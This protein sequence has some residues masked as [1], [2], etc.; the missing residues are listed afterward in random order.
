VQ[1]FAWWKVARDGIYFI[2]GSTTPAHVRILDVA[3]QRVK[4]IASMDLGYVVPGAQY[5]DL[6]P[7]GQW[8]LFD[9]GDQVESDIMLVEN[10]R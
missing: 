1:A 10:F 7:D 5:F 2:D 9:R 8:I 4:T 6:S 3:T